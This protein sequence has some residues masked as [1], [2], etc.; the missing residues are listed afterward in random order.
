MVNAGSVLCWGD[1]SVGQLGNG[2]TT[3]SNKPVAVTGLSV[4]V[5][6]LS[7]GARHACAQASAAKVLCWGD[8]SSGQLGTGNTTSSPTPVPVSGL[9]N[10][11]SG[12]SAGVR[13]T[14]A[15]TSGGSAFCWGENSF[16]ELGPPTPPLQ[17]RYRGSLLASLHFPLDLTLHAQL[18]TSDP[19][20]AG[21]TVATTNWATVSIL[22]RQRR[23]WFLL[24]R[25]AWQHSRQE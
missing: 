24:T 18:W 8:N 6:A 12:L 2:S 13:S 14:C 10:D 11:L 7:A 17:S 21:E 23:C 15:F 22:T 3:S 9:S 16:G 19:Y 25:A 1:N 4:G 5:T 20:G